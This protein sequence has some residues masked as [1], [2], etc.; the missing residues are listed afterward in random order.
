MTVVTR[1]MLLAAGRGERLRPLT[2]HHPK[3]LIS[4]G[5]EPMVFRVLALLAAAGIREV[6]VNT[7][8]L[9]EQIPATLGDGSRWGLRLAYH[10]EQVILGTGGG[11]ANAIRESPQLAEGPLLMINSDILVDADLSAV[12]AHHVALHADSNTA[13]T[14]VLRPDPQ[15]AQYGAIATDDAGRIR[16]FLHLDTGGA[17]REYMFTGIQVISP[18]CLTYLNPAGTVFPITDSYMAALRAGE[19]LAAFVHHGY[20]SDLGTPE[21]LLQAEADLATGRVTF[22]HP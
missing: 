8:H 20:W 9:G 4:L 17:T 10:T 6:H 1:A 2:D 11:L 5:G 13:A 12:I 21:R 3:P 14:L 15:A 18:G 22:P 7:H 16:R 19:H